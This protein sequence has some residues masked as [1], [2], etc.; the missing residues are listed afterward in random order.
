[1]IHGPLVVKKS[2]PPSSENWNLKNCLHGET[3]RKKKQK[4]QIILRK[5]R[6][7]IQKFLFLNLLRLLLLLA[8]P[9]P[10]LS[11]SLCSF[12]CERFAP[13]AKASPKQQKNEETS[14][15]AEEQSKVASAERAK[16]SSL[17]FFS[18]FEPGLYEIYCKKNGK[19]YIGEA[20]NLL[21][22]LGKHARDLK[23]GKADCMELQKDWEKYG[24]FEFEA[25]II[26]IGPEWGKR[27]VRVKKENEIILMYKP[28]EVY[29]TH[30]K[31][32]KKTTENYRI[33]CQ[34]QGKIY[35]SIGEASRITG[36]SETQIQ[37]KLNYNFPDYKII[38]KIK[39]GYKPVVADGE[40]FESIVDAVKAGKAKD[41]FE[42]YRNIKDPNKP[43]WHYVL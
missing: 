22:R 20:G 29:N 8:L 17:N 16:V 4:K 9:L 42:L 11:L 41:R 36:E 14:K 35:N 7:N 10:S 39:H 21:E 15:E 1:M 23:K 19:R 24:P 26:S 2:L 38:D 18:A 6:I 33:I 13:R 40:F 43:N 34:I 37:R 5:F 3:L 27:E 31:T 30:P 12:A 25:K 28:E 32:V